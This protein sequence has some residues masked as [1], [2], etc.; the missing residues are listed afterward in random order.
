MAVDIAMNGDEQKYLQDALK[1]VSNETW[2]SFWGRL[3]IVLGS[4]WGLLGIDRLGIIL[5]ERF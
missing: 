4:L 1:S 2:A 3:G 5:I